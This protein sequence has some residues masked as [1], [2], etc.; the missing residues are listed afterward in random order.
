MMRKIIAIDE[1]KCDGCGAC[2]DACHEGAIGMRQGKAVLLRDDYCDGL[3][4]CLPA[5]P[6]D[7]STFEEREALPYDEA[8]VRDNMSHKHTPLPCG[9]PGSHTRLLSREEFVASVPAG[10]TRNSAS[11]LRQWPVQIQLAPANAA[12]F[13]GAE[14]LIAADCAAYAYGN[15]HAEFMRGRMTLIGCPKLDATDYSEKLAE[16]FRLN[17]IHSVM[18]ARM[19]V[20]CCGGLAQAVRGALCDCGRNIPGGCAVLSTEGAVLENEAL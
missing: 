17:D 10:E 19:S 5:C 9:C 6:M 12:F 8:A 7:A 14:L 1:E 15:F 18:V 2:V 13:S 11:E 3:G 16:I 20:P 4:D